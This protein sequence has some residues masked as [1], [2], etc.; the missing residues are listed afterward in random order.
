MLRL[1]LQQATCHKPRP[2][3]CKPTPLPPAPFLFIRVSVLF[4]SPLPPQHFP[5]PFIY[6]YFSFRF[7]TFHWFCSVLPDLRSHFSC[8]S[9]RLHWF[10][11]RSIWP[12]TL[13]SSL[14]PP[15]PSTSFGSTACLVTSLP[16]L[17]PVTTC[18]YVSPPFQALIIIM[19]FPRNIFLSFNSLFFFLLNACFIFR[20]IIF[21]PL[22]SFP[23]A[24]ICNFINCSLTSATY[25][26]PFRA[27]SVLDLAKWHSSKL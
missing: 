13:N 23:R 6:F 25:K 10:K 19:F 21:L 17:F 2:S 4:P 16:N 12:Q 14:N 11:V 24:S 20:F 3:A 18:T 27:F 8:Q 7:L 1:L 15:C 26:K 5:S 9:P 22:C